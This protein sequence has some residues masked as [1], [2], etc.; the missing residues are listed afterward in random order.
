MKNE[1]GARVK[2]HKSHLGM[3]FTTNPR[4]R[5]CV[6][7]AAAMPNHLTAWLLLVGTLCGLGLLPMALTE[8]PGAQDPVHGL[9]NAIPSAVADPRFSCKTAYRL[10][11][12][13]D[14]PFGRGYQKSVWRAQLADGRTVVLKRPATNTNQGLALFDAAIRAETRYIDFLKQRSS[15]PHLIMARYGLCPEAHV[16]AVEDKLA[17]LD[18][19]GRAGDL[20]WCFRMLLWHQLLELVFSLERLGVFH[21]DLK[22]DQVTVSTD[23]HLRLVDLDSIR[24]QHQPPCS[25]D[26]DCHG[27]LYHALSLHT[28]G[29]CNRATGMCLGFDGKTA[30]QLLAM[31]FSPV[32][33]GQDFQWLGAH[34]S[35]G[36]LADIQALNATFGARDRATRPVLAQALEL[37]GAQ[38]EW[39]GVGP[40]LEAQRAN[41]TEVIEREYWRRVDS[42]PARCSAAHRYC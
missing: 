23:H 2:N 31:T 36:V 24:A 18:F 42:A 34:L 6:Q 17:S 38:M 13:S 7:P 25:T 40:C 35:K 29:R 37:W 30:L 11:N 32:L 9:L 27:C 22:P 20:P 26:A 8:L 14:A 15:H 33:F 4:A 39:A 19:V 41:I 3:H 12:T 21:C 16:A 1:E 10:L 5:R 28:D